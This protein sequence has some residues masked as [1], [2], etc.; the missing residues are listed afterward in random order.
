MK[1]A[2]CVRC[3]NFSPIKIKKDFYALYCEKH[4]LPVRVTDKSDLEL[5][6]EACRFYTG[7][8]RFDKKVWK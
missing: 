3:D 6:A 4:A 1:K 7:K 8:K 5:A 2:S